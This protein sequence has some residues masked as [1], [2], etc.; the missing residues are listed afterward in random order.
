[1][2]RRAEDLGAFGLAG[3]GVGKEVGEAATGVLADLL[4][5]SLLERLQVQ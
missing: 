1:M 4:P 5:H 2:K 3:G